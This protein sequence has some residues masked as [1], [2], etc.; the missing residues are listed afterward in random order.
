MCIIELL[1][2]LIYHMTCIYVWS[3]S[4]FPAC[5]IFIHTYM[6]VSI[7]YVYVCSVPAF[8]F[9]SY[10][11][12]YTYTNTYI[13]TTAKE[14]VSCVYY[15]CMIRIQWRLLSMQVGIMCMHSYCLKNED[16]II[17]NIYYINHHE[18]ESQQLYV[19]LVYVQDN[20]VLMNIL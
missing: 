18:D 2:V 15:I 14:M 10:V 3:L 8:N 11:I 12:W 13:Y 6:H 5:T 19:C 9:P 1:T 20:L 16:T 4:R 7:V 17:V